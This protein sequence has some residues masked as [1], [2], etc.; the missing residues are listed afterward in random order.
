[1]AQ[2]CV[3]LLPPQFSANAAAAVL[4]AGGI[5]L[6]DA[7]GN[8]GGEPRGPIEQ[9]ALLRALKQCREAAV[10]PISAEAQGGPPDGSLAAVADRRR[11]DPALRLNLADLP[12][13]EALY[14]ISHHV[15]LRDWTPDALPEVLNAWQR[16]GRQIWLELRDCARLAEVDPSLPF[17]GWLGRG[18][19]SAGEPGRD[20]AFILAQHLARQPKPFW[21]QGG[22]GVNSATAAIVCGAQRVVLDDAL[23]LLREPALPA[24]W[25][26]IIA[27]RA[28]GRR[29]EGS[30][31]ALETLALGQGA[32]QA[33][34]LAARWRSVGALIAAIDAACSERIATAGRQQA[35]APGAAL[36]VVH[37]TEFPIVQGPMTRVSDVP[38]F[39]LDVARAGALPMLALATMPGAQARK[40]LDAARAA[41]GGRPWGVGLLGYVSP[42]LAAEQFEALAAVRPPFAVI[43]GGRPDQAQRLATLGI[44]AYIHVP[45]P[46]L[47][48]LFVEQGQR[49]FIF[50]GGECGGH[51]GPLYSLP[52]WDAMVD[53]LLEVLP[54]GESADVLFAGGIHDARSAA[55]VAAIA[56][57]LVERG[58]RIGVLMGSAYLFTTEA[59][60]SGAISAS[61]QEEARRCEATALIHTVPGHRIRCAPTPYVDVVTAR[62]EALLR[63]GVSAGAAGAEIE[64]ML[65]GRLRLASKGLLRADG[66]L[67]AVEPERVRADG[68]FMMGDVASLRAAPLTCAE[69]HREVGEGAPAR[70]A[71]LAERVAGGRAAV[72][73]PPPAEPV[74]II[75]IGCLL[76]GAQGPQALWRNLLDGVD[77][78][79]E[80][81]SERWDWR[82]YYDADP[83]ARDRIVSRWGGFI[84][85]LPFDPLRYGIPPKSLASICIAQLLALEATRRAFADAGLGDLANAP[86]LRERTA[87]VF[88][89]ASTGDLELM[90]KARSALPLAVAAPEAAFARLPEW[91]EESYP[92]ILVNVIAGRVANRFDLGGCNFTVDAA[93]ASS[94]AALDIAVR[95]LQSGRS[96]LALAGAV[97]AELSPHA[98]L[99]FSKTQALSPRGRASV[100]DTKADGIVISEGAVVLVLKRL[101]D[102]ERDGDR[103]YATLRALA[104]SS[105]GKGMGL[106]AP[107]PA[108]QV[109]AVQRA[110]AAAR[111]RVAGLGLYEAHGTGTRVGDQ[112]E[113]ETLTR[114]L[115]AD[116]APPGQ[117]VVGSAKSILGHTRAAAGLVGVAKAALALHHR[118]LPPHAGVT[119][120]LPALRAPGAPVRL[121]ATP[122]PWLAREDAPRRAGVSAFGFG[123]TNFHAVLE[124]HVESGVPGARIRP[125]ELVVVAAPDRAGLAAALDRLRRAAI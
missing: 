64:Q 67:V 81:P 79:G 33:A 12:L 13:A 102:A 45:T 16:E 38:E 29:I 97:E 4:R 66:G 1:M 72:A 59:V 9:A 57:P 23:L 95:E 94:L 6:V 44:A 123:G 98:F 36:A 52:L 43:A 96:D 37:G 39:A 78:I 121:L 61:F 70:L 35:L 25:R 49:R 54:A 71:E 89:A 20:S 31:P 111:T 120:P 125:A 87:A 74:A 124:E 118:V 119:E 63:A 77:A 2:R 106:T 41:L 46:A 58:S 15:V 47:L 56:T 90:Y 10:S 51:A 60:A 93:C 86:A 28:D 8:R 48:R 107:K 116:G 26:P 42:E 32:G 104:G 11:G 68:V 91:T 88:G 22:I 92:G 24:S 113:I 53:T 110:H 84:G 122:Q 100:F 112:A 40:L 62:H 83:A 14:G 108:G 18:A 5:A 82:L 105:D 115:S 50:E 3:C 103:I 17:A 19:E 30:D 34:A 65:V 75:G 101:A 117:C 73:A 80:I 85:A 69:L 114:A 27:A 55:A 76:P 99:A 7:A 109:L 21:L